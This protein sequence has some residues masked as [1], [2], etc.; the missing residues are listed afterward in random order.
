MTTYLITDFGAQSST[1]AHEAINAAIAAAHAAGGG[2]VEIPAGTWTS[3]TIHLRSHVELHLCSGAVLTASADQEL[4]SR[5]H[6]NQHPPHLDKNNRGMTSFILGTDCV[7]IAI[8]GFGTI[9]ADSFELRPRG[10]FTIC[11]MRCRDVRIMDCTIRN[12]KGWTCLT[13]CCDNV[14]VRGVTMRNPLSTG[15]GFD[16]DGCRDVRFSDCDIITGDD[17]IVIK[18]C[19]PTRS[20]ERI[21]ITNCIMRTSCAAVKIGTETWHD[22]RHVTVSNCVVHKSGRAIE[23]FSMDGGT[24]EDVTVSNLTADTNSGIIFNRPLHIDCC[25]RRHGGL[26]PDVDHLAVPAG[27]IRRITISD[28]LFV[29]DGRILL[30]GSDRARTHY[31][32]QYST[33]H[34]LD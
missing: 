23:I 28:C 18:T 10:Y 16:V 7:D 3:G 11:F 13:S 4:F 25:L 15:D 34:A 8:T 17:C 14:M 27:R 19:K 26:L 32:A 29:S 21:V 5:R 24:I 1:P 33:H 9:D 12:A 31:P 30:T 6:D 22:V 2:R 20:S